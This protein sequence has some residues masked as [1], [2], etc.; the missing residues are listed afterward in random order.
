MDAEALAVYDN[1]GL[2]Y[3]LTNIAIIAFAM[4]VRVPPLSRYL[5]D[6]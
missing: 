1:Q 5:L 2:P 6:D 4:G 3:L